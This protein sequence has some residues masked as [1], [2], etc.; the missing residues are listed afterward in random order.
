MKVSCVNL[1]CVLW[2]SINSQHYGTH[3]HAVTPTNERIHWSRLVPSRSFCRCP[4]TSFNNNEENTKTKTK[5]KK[6]QLVICGVL[7]EEEHE[8]VKRE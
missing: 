7:I 4:F 3:Q 1:C 8:H 5:T 2:N 6:K